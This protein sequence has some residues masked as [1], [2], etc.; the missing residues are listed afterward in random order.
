MCYHVHLKPIHTVQ[1]SAVTY[2]GYP[3]CWTIVKHIQKWT[4]PN[5]Q[6]AQKDC[7]GSPYQTEQLSWEMF[8][9]QWVNAMLTCVISRLTFTNHLV[10]QNYSTSTSDIGDHVQSYAEH[11]T[12]CT[13]YSFMNGGIL[14][15]EF[16]P[17]LCSY[18]RWTRF[19][20]GVKRT[21]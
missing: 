3:R 5:S 8:L 9:F 14:Y 6:E 19:C 7:K 1:H 12:T 13:V 18:F 11:F 21:S 15:W 17:Q 2:H 4:T 16:G 20:D 10:I